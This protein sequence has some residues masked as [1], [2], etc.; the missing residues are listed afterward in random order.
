MA[1]ILERLQ[2][3]DGFLSDLD[4][5]FSRGLNVIIGPRGVG[6]TSI[7]ELL[8]FCLTE[9]PEESS[10]EH[11]LAVLGPDGKVTVTMRD[12]QREIVV[13]RSA[14]DESPQSTSQ[15]RRAPLIFSQAEI[16]RV[17]LEPK[18]RLKII[19]GFANVESEG[20]REERRMEAAIK[21]YTLQLRQLGQDLENAREQIESLSNVPEQLKE[22]AD[23]QQFVL[24]SV[25]ESE[26]QQTRLRSLGTEL[27]SETRRIKQFEQAKKD[28]EDWQNEIRLVLQR[29]P[30]IGQSTS[31]EEEDLLS[32]TRTA[33]NH[34]KVLLNK[35]ASE[36]DNS[37]RELEEIR[38]TSQKKILVLEEDARKLRRELEQL[39]AGAGTAAQKVAVLQEKMGQLEALRG[40]SNELMNHIREIRMQRGTVLSELQ[41]LRDKRYE[42]RSRVAASLTEDLAPN[43][44]ISVEQGGESPS[45]VGAIQAALRGSGLHH[46]ILAPQLAQGMSPRELAEAVERGDQE[47]IAQ[48]TGISEDRAIKAIAAISRSGTEDIITAPIHDRVTM[49][50]L[51]GREYKATTELS[52]GQRCTVVLSVLLGYQGRGL[53]IDQPEDHLDNAYIV[54]TLIDALQRRKTQNQLIF[55]THN[56][57]IPVLGDADLVIVLGS[58]GQR[59]FVRH[60]APLNDSTIVQAITSVMEGGHEAFE[61]RAKFY[62]TWI[63]L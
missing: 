43:I 23:A 47:E 55:T 58:D 1:I 40:R 36:L 4:V 46:N 29:S 22:A 13:S 62:R 26:K 57:N 12:G 21:S 6:K 3:E 18:S 20:G 8:R 16:E 31:T 5:R 19:D 30:R 11:A 53:I 42:F 44:E 39:K 51:D 2:V 28:L 17:G 9:N 61:R 37:I 54:S 59:G 10:L 35:G 15:F 27:A 63:K 34:V 32:N 14:N 41:A 60:A 56:A 33:V 24:R 38:S 45:Y 52:T 49:K 7:V 50:L 48:L 25:K